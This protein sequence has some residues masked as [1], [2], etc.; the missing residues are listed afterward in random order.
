[1]ACNDL[2]L[3][4]E[5]LEI[6]ER[7]CQERIGELRKRQWQLVMQVK[8]VKTEIQQVKKELEYVVSLQAGSEWQTPLTDTL[9]TGTLESEQALRR[10]LFGK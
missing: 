8:Q 4:R 3:T 2:S 9:K 5:E 7:E 10:A 6:V 1:M